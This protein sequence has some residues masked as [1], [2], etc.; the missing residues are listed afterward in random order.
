MSE[1]HPDTRA[2]APEVE[3]LKSAEAWLAARGV[4]RQSIRLQPRPDDQVV[5]DV[6]DAAAPASTTGATPPVT[7]PRATET[8]RVAEAAA[9]ERA[10]LAD[11]EAH[12]PKQGPNLSDDVAR[13]VAYI[14]NATARTPM[15]TGRL[16][17]RLAERDTIDQVIDLAIRQAGQEGLVDDRAYGAA[18]VSEGLAKG[19]APTRIRDD[20]FKRDFDRPLI[21]ELIAQAES[22]DPEAAAF[23]VARDRADQLS[24]L[25][26]E[27]AYRRLVAYLARRGHAEGLARKVARQVLWVEREGAQTAGH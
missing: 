24:G 15:S 6:T 23:A 20:L 25:E 18:I 26:P 13:A 7:E 4:E 9:D 27:K 8:G 5:V 14:R 1:A 19:H 11:L 21:V 3:D 22:P 16:R 17:R 10:R 2:D 12:E